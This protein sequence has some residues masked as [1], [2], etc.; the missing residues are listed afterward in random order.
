MSALATK[1]KKPMA[2]TARLKSKV[3]REFGLNHRN[4]PKVAF[5][6]FLMISPF[7]DLDGRIQADFEAVRR[8]L[9]IQRSQLKCAL[10]RLETEGLIE[11]RGDHY[12]SLA[13]T[14]GKSGETQFIQNYKKIVDGS[15]KKHSLRVNRLISYFLSAKMPGKVHRVKFENLYRNQLHTGLAGIDYFYDAKEAA[16]ALLKLIQ[17]DVISIWLGRGQD[18]LLLPRGSGEEAEKALYSYLGLTDSESPKRSRTSS[19]KA[20]NHVLSIRLTDL[21]ISEKVA[22]SANTA[23]LDMMLNRYDL[24]IEELSEET[25]Q[26]LIGAKNT[27][28]NKVGETGLSIYRKAMESYCHENCFLASYHDDQE[29]KVYDVM[30]NNYLLKEIQSVLLE[31]AECNKRSGYVSSVQYETSHGTITHRHFEILLDYFLEIGTPEYEMFLRAALRDAGIQIELL[32]STSGQW[33]RIQIRAEKLKANLL[34]LSGDVMT[35]EECEEFL[36]SA[37]EKRLLIQQEEYNRL[38]ERHLRIHFLTKWEPKL[39]NSKPE[40]KVPFYNWLEDRN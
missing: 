24:Y 30:R 25:I 17:D 38:V 18:A 27:L 12:Y 33:L 16:A 32:V 6:V 21:F 14:F 31:V 5:N 10:T 29:Y 37:A 15:M 22:V 8:K 9:D 1:H 23:E 39:E 2:I 7:V 34:A 26:Q 28:F 40:P 11:R 35:D 20:E 36:L 19:I 3:V 4:I 13:H